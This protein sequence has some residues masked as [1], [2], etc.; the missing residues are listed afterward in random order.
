M[1][2]WKRRSDRNELLYD[3]KV[4]GGDGNCTTFTDKA[5][6][7]I[8]ITLPYAPAGANPVAIA[9]WYMSDPGL[10]ALAI[11]AD[12]RKEQA[13]LAAWH[14]SRTR[15]GTHWAVPRSCRSASWGRGPNRPPRPPARQGNP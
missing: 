12:P 13:R 5:C 3:S 15:G 6:Q 11:E 4:S 9:R 14:C 10:V 7:A 8:G 2:D 1:S